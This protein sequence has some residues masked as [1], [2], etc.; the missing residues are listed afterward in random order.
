MGSSTA[1]VVSY[2]GEFLV[3]PLPSGW[4][5]NAEQAD[6]IKRAGEHQLYRPGP[7][8]NLEEAKIRL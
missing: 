8:L 7:K 2:D 6:C 1:I 4:T 5:L 3:K